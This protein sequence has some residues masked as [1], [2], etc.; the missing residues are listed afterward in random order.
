MCMLY[1][2]NLFTPNLCNWKTMKWISKSEISI[3][4]ICSE[5]TLKA[6]S[7]FCWDCL[8]L[9]CELLPKQFFHEGLYDI[10]WFANIFYNYSFI[11]ASAKL[12]F[13]EKE[14]M[15]VLPLHSFKKYICL[16]KSNRTDK[17]MSRPFQNLLKIRCI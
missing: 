14:S 3:L 6:K 13:P 9:H 5:I 11:T 10:W 15:W 7:K 17:S 12:V 4:W 8:L 16:K 1:C 2:G